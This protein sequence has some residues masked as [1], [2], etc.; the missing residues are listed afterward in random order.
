[1]EMLQ[2]VRQGLELARLADASGKTSEIPDLLAV[3]AVSAQVALVLA[4]Q[5]LTDAF[6]ADRVPSGPLEVIGYLPPTGG[7]AEQLHPHPGTFASDATKLAYMRSHGDC[8]PVW[9]YQPS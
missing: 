4:V 2:G 6:R 8:R 3:A 1:M 9:V 7:T 5:E